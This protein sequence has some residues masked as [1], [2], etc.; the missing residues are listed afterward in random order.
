MSAKGALLGSPVYYDLAAKE[1]EFMDLNSKIEIDRQLVLEENTDFGNMIQ[2]LSLPVYHMA[3][4]K[5][6]WS[7][8]FLANIGFSHGEKALL[9]NFRNPLRQPEEEYAWE[10]F[11]RLGFD[12]KKGMLR[13]LPTEPKRICYE[14]QGDT[15]MG[16]KNKC[17]FTYGPRSDY[18]AKYYVQDM[19]YSYE[20][21]IDL[22]LTSYFY[23]GDTCLNTFRPLELFIYYP[24]AFSEDSRRK[25]ENLPL[26]LIELSPYLAN[27][28]VANSVYIDSTFLINVPFNASEE[29]RLLS[30]WGRPLEESDP[31]FRELVAFDRGA[32]KKH[33]LLVAKLKKQKC[34]RGAFRT[35]T[36]GPAV[37]CGYE[38][39]I[40]QLWDRGAQI[41]PVY[42]SQVEP[43]GAGA[44][45]CVLFLDWLITP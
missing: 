8:M 18:E 28:F 39:F 23:H 43:S 19:L 38:W 26:D 33:A 21:L 10:W 12:P 24:G 3:P 20:E 37:R 7:S 5:Y 17:F 40:R 2:R 42:M 22:E 14:G 29:S 32:W 30:A 25:I 4:W 41:I 11:Q 35:A 13:R 36:H 16:G 27:C 31:R 1:N 6:G 44:R 34:I 45:C 15:L 9:A